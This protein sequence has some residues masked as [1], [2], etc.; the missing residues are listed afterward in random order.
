MRG[1][2]HHERRL[3]QLLLRE[4]D[5]SW[6][7][8]PDVQEQYVRLVSGGDLS[9]G[10]SSEG[11]TGG[12]TANASAAPRAGGGSSVERRASASSL[13]PGAAARPFYEDAGAASVPQT[14]TSSYLSAFFL[15]LT[16][17]AGAAGSGAG[18]GA[19]ASSSAAATQNVVTSRLAISTCSSST[20]LVSSATGAA[21]HPV[22]GQGTAP[23]GLPPMGPHD[24]WLVSPKA[25]RPVSVGRVRPGFGPQQAGPAWVRQLH[26]TSLGGSSAMRCMSSVPSADLQVV[27]ITHS[28]RLNYLIVDIRC[29][30]SHACTKQGRACKQSHETAL[31]SGVLGD[32]SWPFGHA[33]L[34]FLAR[35]LLARL[36]DR[37]KLLFDTVCTLADLSYDVFHSSVDVDMAGAHQV[38]YV[39]P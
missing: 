2:I 8:S 20:S 11:S 19:G 23:G 14:P 36:Q 35:T 34:I 30:A 1:A 32:D 33:W 7:R 3:H 37:K 29:R 10:S 15:P 12:G 31:G 18:V 22:M 16:T 6:E 21:P 4:E 13:A 26:I 25:C 17:L 38:F 9:G 24:P 5:S 28:R 27:Q 39:R